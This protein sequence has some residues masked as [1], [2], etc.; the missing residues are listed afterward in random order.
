MLAIAALAAGVALPVCGAHAQTLA[1]LYNFTG[2]ADGAMPYSGLIKKGGTLY[3]T[4]TFGGIPDCPNG[5]G[6]VYS[7]TPAGNETVLHAF[8]GGVDGEYP[9]GYLINVRGNFYGTTASGGDP[10][11]NQTRGCGTVF[12]VTPGGVET[13]LHSFRHGHDDGVFPEAGLTYMGGKL[14]G[15]TTR[16]GANKRGTVYSITL[17]GHEKVLYSFQGGTDGAFPEADM[18]NVDGVL[19]GTT[20][21]GGGGK[22]PHGCGTVFT[23]TPAGVETVLH[24][25]T[26]K[27]GAYPGAPLINVGGTVYGTTG[28]GGNAPCATNARSSGCGTVFLVTASGVEVVLHSFT[29]GADGANPYGLTLVNGKFFGTTVNGGGTGC[30]GFG[31]GTLFK[32]ENFGFATQYSSLSSFTGGSDAANPYGL[33]HLGSKLYGTSLYGGAFGNG[34]VFQFTP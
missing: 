8:T 27:D 12:S 25:F 15:T 24:A 21:Y 9:G 31:C 13:V 4:T 11:C 14:Y 1:T 32:I 6:T 19:Y 30:F 7:V 5:C 33:V 17:S 23:I 28:F 16:G 20:T 10:N 22:C 2:G 29:G 26:G 18:V 3:G 34:T